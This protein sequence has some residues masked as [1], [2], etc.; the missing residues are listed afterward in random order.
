MKTA[1]IIAALM[2]RVP[3]FTDLFSDSFTP[4]TVTVA[5]SL[6]TIKKT[7]HGLADGKIIT[8]S[9]AV[10]LTPVVNIESGG[11]AG[12]TRI[13]TATPHDATEEYSTHVVLSSASDQTVA[14]SYPI[15][16]VDTRTEII[17]T[18]SI[19]DTLDDVFLHEN[20]EYSVNGIFRISRIDDDH[21]SVNL[22][23]TLGPQTVILPSALK[24]HHRVRIS[25]GAEITRLIENYEKQAMNALW[26]FVVLDDA[27][28]NKDR[29][30]R[31]D[32]ELEQGGGNE[33][34]ALL[35]SPFS[36]YVFIP[37]ENEITGRAARDT[38]EDV[39]PILYKSIV[40]M[41]FDSGFVMSPDSKVFPRGD[42]LTAY[43]KAFYVHRF[44]FAQIPIITGNDTARASKTVPLQSVQFDFLKTEIDTVGVMISGLVEIDQPED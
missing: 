44:M 10:T 17:F 4:E 33:W 13:E 27:Q 39:R 1:D 20:R 15:L 43:M 8:L 40:G 29:N 41:A 11:D 31:S 21:F 28:I 2:E 14:G 9:N 24:V 22:P 16:S 3:Q 36:V 6:V 30:T 25:G 5:G 12:W 34:S 26:A 32:A 19:D 37:C 35:L 42:Q 7:K 23:Y 18:G 38:A